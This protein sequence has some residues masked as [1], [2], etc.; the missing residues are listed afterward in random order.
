M[1]APAK[2]SV[3]TRHSRR[4]RVGLE[5]VGGGQHPHRM[6]AGLVDHDD[7]RGSQVKMPAR[8]Q[9]PT[10][11]LSR[12]QRCRCG[13]GR[14]APH[15]AYPCGATAGGRRRDRTRRHEGGV[16]IDHP[17]APKANAEVSRLARHAL[18]VPGATTRA[19]ARGR[20]APAV[21]PPV[22]WHV[23]HGRQV[24][25]VGGRQWML[26][27]LHRGK[28]RVGQPTG[29]SQVAQAR[30]TSEHA[31]RSDT[32]TGRLAGPA[33]RA[34]RRLRGRPVSGDA[35]GRPHGQRPRARDPRAQSPVGKGEQGG[36][37]VTPECFQSAL[38][39]G[40]LLKVWQ[41]DIYVTVSP[42]WCV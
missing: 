9:S 16:V 27:A 14:T 11:A 33:H 36:F 22:R 23:E 6:A 29:A 21:T 8:M 30:V 26:A 37:E 12:R 38:I 42:S 40:G 35:R 7:V 5:V 13:G 2:S 39:H 41:H 34:P 4:R 31:R 32:A 25:G 3:L 10:W 24:A 20:S 28:V 15:H 18:D 19:Q 17:T 1:G